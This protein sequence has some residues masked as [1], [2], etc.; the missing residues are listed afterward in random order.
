M[1]YNL[2]IM[3]KIEFIATNYPSDVTDKEWAIIEPF[4]P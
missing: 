4:F 1:W 2:P 3:K